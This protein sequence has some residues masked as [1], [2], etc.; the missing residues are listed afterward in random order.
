M[1]LSVSASIHAGYEGDIGYTQLVSEEGID[2]PDG[3]GIRVT[4]IE[5]STAGSGNPAVYLPDGSHSEFATTTITD[6]SG[7]TTSTFSSHATSVGKT[8]YGGASSI[9]P[10]MSL[11]D[12]FLADDWLQGGFLRFGGMKP[13]VSSSRIANH[14]WIGDFGVANNSDLLRR[15]DWVVARDEFIQCVG[16]KN[17]ASANQPLMSSAYN[18]IAVGKSDGANGF[19]AAA[20]DTDYVSGRTRPE[21]VAPKSTSSSATPVVAAST[22]L[23]IEHGQNNPSLSTDPVETSTS[24][25]Y[26]DTIYNTGRS[27]VIKAVLMAGA[28]RS[29]ANTSISDITDYR[30]DPINQTTNGLD[31]RFGAGQ[32]N[33]YNSFQIID[34]GEQNSDE[35]IGAGN[36]SAD[37]FD[38]D[39]S[40]GGSGG[41]NSLASYYFSTG[42][43]QVMLSTTLAWNIKIDGGNGTD[44]SGAAEL[45]DLDLNLYDITGSKVLLESS[46]STIDNTETIWVQ[47]SANRSYLLEVVR[48][49]GQG[50][51]KWDYALA[52]HMVDIIIDSDGDGIPDGKDT[53]DDNDGMPDSWEISNNLNPLDSSDASMDSDSDGL[54]NLQEYEAGSNPGNPDTDTDGLMDGAEVNIYGTDPTDA[55][56]DNDGLTDGAEVNTYGTDPTDAD[57]DTDNDG[58]PDSVDNC[59]FIENLNQEDTDG[60]SIGD[61]CVDGSGHGKGKEILKI[62]ECGKDINYAMYDIQLEPDGKWQMESPSGSYSGKYEVAIPDEKLSLS[63]SNKSKSRLYE[64]IGQAGKSLCKVKGKILSPKVTKFIVKLDDESDVLKV[65]LKVKYKATDGTTKSKGIYKVVINAAYAS[66]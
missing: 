12:A 7:A 49:S 61:A 62:E 28:D 11:V 10:G 39:P 8:F 51:F 63:L 19:G 4:Q 21:L 9:A 20:I 54:T 52:W 26:G 32:V 65:V 24:N 44:F 43:D 35:D 59:P 31:P 22:A 53:D 66:N 58:V 57:T 41:S 14:S 17:N 18:V 48:G 64:Y 5:A 56:T 60:D 15:T 50:L 42:A 37:G 1:L 38:Y 27:E 33:I 16:V 40:F 46:R 3:S 23:L 45:Y 55:D 13:L 2:T 34:A 36:I 25:R 47:L 30:A 6:K 29:T